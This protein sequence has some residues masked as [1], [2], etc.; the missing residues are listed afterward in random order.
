M[1]LPVLSPPV[2]L[3]VGAPCVTL[4]GRETLR[5]ENHRG[6]VG[7]SAEEISMNAGR[8][9]IRI[10]GSGLELR[11]MTDLEAIITGRI[12]SVEYLE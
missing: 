9:I 5:L 11:D 12:Y 10:R 8:Y 3:S 4:T 2:A 7:F 6:L 1:D